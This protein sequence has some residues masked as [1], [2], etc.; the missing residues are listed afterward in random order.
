MHATKSELYGG[1]AAKAADLRARGDAL[2]QR[3]GDRR[4]SN[5]RRSPG[6]LSLVRCAESHFDHAT[7]LRN[8]SRRAAPAESSGS[9]DDASPMIAARFDP[10]AQGITDG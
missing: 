6:Y 4:F 3:G 1:R 9:T 10:I 5:Y 8:R 7:A 2:R